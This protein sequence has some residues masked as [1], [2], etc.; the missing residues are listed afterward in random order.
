MSIHSPTAQALSH[1]E[2][3]FAEYTTHG[4]ASR[5]LMIG[6]AG[7][8]IVLLVLLLATWGVQAEVVKLGYVAG[9]LT[10]ALAALQTFD[11]PFSDRQRVWLF[12]DGLVLLRGKSVAGVQW[13]ELNALYEDVSTRRVGPL[14]LSRRHTYTI[15]TTDGRELVL[16]HRLHNVERLGDALKDVLSRRQLPHAVKAL[17]SGGTQTFG[18]VSISAAGV[19]AAGALVPWKDIRQVQL[20]GGELRIEARSGAAN[21][22]T[23]PA[24]AIPNAHIFLTLVQRVVGNR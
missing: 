24:S 19:H 17:K 7:L 20:T 1:R 18:P 13:T 15:R 23:I 8:A 6:G 3:P 21:G 5:A 4:D 16:N 14:T 2:R 22:K 12:N 11:L 9:L 10:M